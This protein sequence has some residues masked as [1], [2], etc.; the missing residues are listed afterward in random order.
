MCLCGLS[1]PF[2]GLVVVFVF[3]LLYIHATCCM[4]L[5]FNVEFTSNEMC[6]L[7]ERYDTTT[8]PSNVCQQFSLWGTTANVSGLLV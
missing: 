5:N 1:V 7:R 6:F 3:D 4:H 2:E 8:N